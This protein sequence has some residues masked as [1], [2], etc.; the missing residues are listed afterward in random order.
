MFRLLPAA[1]ALLSFAAPPPVGNAVHLSRDITVASQQQVGS[2]FCFLCSIRLDGAAHGNLVAFAGNIYL[3]GPVHKDILALGG[4]VTLTGRAAVDGRVIVFGGHLYRD[5]VATIGRG[6]VVLRP[7]IFLPMLLVI[8]VILA[9]LLF[10]L[11]FTT[12]RE[13]F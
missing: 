13:R 1:F 6:R 3:N 2:A 5:P 12:P 7:I 11:R 9:A 8:A 10:L 4:N